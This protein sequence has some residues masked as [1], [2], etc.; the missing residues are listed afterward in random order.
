MSELSGNTICFTDDN[1][2]TVS[3]EVI[4]ETRING[5]NYLLVADGDE[6]YIFK[7][8]SDAQ[9]EEAAYEPVEEEREIDYI[10]GIFSELLEDMDLT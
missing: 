6:A 1:G 4:E 8:V 2:E 7:E 5:V 3:L 10:S 9:A